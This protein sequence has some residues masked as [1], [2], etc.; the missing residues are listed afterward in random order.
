MRC[1]CPRN[2]FCL[3]NGICV[4]VTNLGFTTSNPKVVCE[5][6]ED[7]QTQDVRGVCDLFCPF[8]MTCE[9][10]EAQCVDMVCKRQPKCVNI[11]SN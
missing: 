5:T 3:Q 2:G 7:C 6:T 10:Q 8:N 4:P 11:K 1:Q 9:L